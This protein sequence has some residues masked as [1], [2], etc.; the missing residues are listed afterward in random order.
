MLQKVYYDNPRKIEKRL[1]DKFK[2]SNFRPST[3]GLGGGVTEWFLI[4]RSEF[5]DLKRELGVVRGWFN[6]SIWVGVILIL[7]YFFYLYIKTRFL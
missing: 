1:H 7:V 6:W 5:K 4:D 3:N 2:T